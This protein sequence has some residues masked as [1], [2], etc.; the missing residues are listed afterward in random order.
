MTYRMPRSNA[1]PTWPTYAAHK[2]NY[3][4][5]RIFKLNYIEIRKTHQHELR[6]CLKVQHSSSN[7][8]APD[9]GQVG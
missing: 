9:D 5:F 3:T 4:D 1:K 7:F 6:Q 2:E 8:N